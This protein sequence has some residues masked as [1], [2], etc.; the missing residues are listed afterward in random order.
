M[1]LIKCPECGKEVSEKTITCPNCGVRVG[2]GHSQKANK[3]VIVCLLIFAALCG[4]AA[5]Y[6]TLHPEIING[7]SNDVEITQSTSSSKIVQDNKQPIFANSPHFF[8]ST[9]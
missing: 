8:D 5:Y 3:I 2:N 9:Q 1:S 7:T 6:I 4:F